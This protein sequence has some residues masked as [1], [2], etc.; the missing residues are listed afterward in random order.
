MDIDASPGEEGQKLGAEDLAIGEGD[1]NFR[2]M[3][4]DHMSLFRTEGFEF[5]NGKLFPICFPRRLSH[6]SGK[7]GLASTLGRG[8]IGE[9]GHE[10]VFLAQ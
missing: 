7:K 2:F 1:E 8:G 4:G 10:F 5:E 3:K 6:G 9:D